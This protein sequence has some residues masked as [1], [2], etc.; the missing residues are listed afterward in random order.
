MSTL[1]FTCTTNVIV[2]DKVNPVAIV[3]QRANV[4]LD[5]Q[6]SHV[7]TVDEL[8]GGSYD[9]CG[10][11]FFQISPSALNCESAKSDNGHDDSMGWF[12]Q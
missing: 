5:A 7:L 8:D 1:V 2:E 10:L 9:G 6:G 12:R 4:E 11:L 3:C